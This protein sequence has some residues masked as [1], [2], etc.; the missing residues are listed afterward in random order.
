MI[1]NPDVVHQAQAELDMVVGE[2][3][4]TFEDKDKL[5]YISAIVKEVSRWRP[6]APSGVPHAA[7]EDFEYD[8]YVIP[9]GT[10]IIDNIWSQTRDTTV[11]VDPDNF[12]PSR[13]LET[14]GQIRPG[15]PDSHDDW[16]GFGH[17]RRICPGRDLATNSLFIA[18]ACLLWAF[19]FRKAKDIDGNEDAVD[20][21][22]LVDN[23]ITVQPAP[24]KADLVRRFPDL[25]HK[26]GLDDVNPA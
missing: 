13:F 8:G 11:Y 12:D 5:P 4:P 24:F 16:L 6:A 3:M 26:L 14:D 10:W 18:F 23:F 21:M 17:G 20:D 7:S 25:D 22:D 9:R 15:P 19:E 1:L 2:R